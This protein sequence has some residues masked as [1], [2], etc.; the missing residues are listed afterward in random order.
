MTMTKKM[1]LGGMKIESPFEK[2]VPAGACLNG[3]LATNSHIDILAS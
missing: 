2:Y 1:A 3:L